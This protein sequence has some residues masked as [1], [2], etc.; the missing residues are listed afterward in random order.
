MVE[1]MGVGEEQSFILSTEH[2]PTEKSLEWQDEIFGI[3]SGHPQVTLRP[4]RGE[5]PGVAPGRTGRLG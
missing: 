4:V 1:S 5:W 3:L 2:S